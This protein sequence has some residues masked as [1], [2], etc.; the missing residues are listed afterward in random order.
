MQ[1]KRVRYSETTETR[2]EKRRPFWRK[3]IFGAPIATSEAKHELMPKVLALPIF[4]S[5]AIS[6]VAYATQQI[7]LALCGAGLWISAYASHYALY[8]VIISALIVALLSVVVL[9]YRQT[10]SAYPGGGGSYAV[11][12]KNLGIFAG[13]TAAAALLIDYVLTVSVSVTAG[14]QNL[15][16]VP[17]LSGLAIRDHMVPYCVLCIALLTLANLRGL[18][19]TG[20]LFAMPTYLFV[21]MCY[22]MIAL[23]LFGPLFGWHFHPEY[24]N[25]SYPKEL[26]AA[27]NAAGSLGAV[28]FLR[29]FANGC[30]AMTGIEAISNSV[31]AFQEPKPKNAADTLVVMAIIL[32][33]IFIGISWLS[34]R[35]HVV[36]WE[37]GGNTAPSV[38]D[39][40]SGAVFGKTGMSG[41]FYLVTQLFT[42]LI[43][44]LAANTSF[45][46]FPRL[47]SILARDGFMPRQ[48]A[49]LGDK[50][51]FNN[52]IFVLGIIS[53]ALVVAKKGSVDALIPFYAIG[54]FL[55][56]TLS[57]AGMVRHWIKT[58]GERWKHK[59][60]INGLGAVATFLVLLDIA[61]E[62]FSEGAWMVMIFGAV[63]VF[64]F[65]KIY[66]H[67]AD[68]ADQLRILKYTQQPQPT[69]NTVLVLVQ[70][71]NTGTL[72]AIDYAR[73]ISDSVISLNVE[74][75]PE[76]TVTLKE[77]WREMFADVPLVVMESPY[78]SLIGPLLNYLD[79]VRQEKPNSRVTVVIGEFVPTK[80]W[81]TLLHGNTGLLLKFAL[82]GRNDVIVANV[83]YKLE[84]RSEFRPRKGFGRSTRPQ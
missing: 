49:N 35:F 19:E 23:G 43:L 58:G 16:D 32:S 39:Q 12:K 57:Q 76:K 37:F 73:S 54:V 71:I 63:L 70:G 78:R 17:M 20:R 74:L 27:R 26:D 62:K 48:L 30:S 66:E 21:G 1:T 33:T 55:A 13:L 60:F 28:L 69:D 47:A 2:K 77:R 61:C 72:Q 10:I 83:R 59:A 31:P 56:F 4:S 68:V 6:S 82:L 52:G 84:N 64:M 80:W 36:Y 40:L 11:S 25:Q 79:R 18:R 51:V 44:V 24:V 38:I 34:V 65:R 9:S 46:S 42:A 29:A 67:Y 75:D 50:L 45:A 7:L 41:W 53:A 81:H 5:D 14:V 8:T 3:L 22:L 15:R